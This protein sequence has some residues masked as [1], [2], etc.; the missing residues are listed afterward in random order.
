MNLLAELTPIELHT[1]TSCRQRQKDL[2]NKTLTAV[3]HLL[4]LYAIL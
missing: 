3:E 2:D 1:A 4:N